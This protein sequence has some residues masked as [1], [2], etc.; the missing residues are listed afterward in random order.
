[1]GK[2]DA[3]WKELLKKELC[4]DELGGEVDDLSLTWGGAGRERRCLNACCA[5]SDILAS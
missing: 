3:D 4:T 5:T 1:M 2:V